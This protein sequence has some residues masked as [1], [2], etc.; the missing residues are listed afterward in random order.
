MRRGHLIEDQIIGMLREHEAGVKIADLCRRHGIS[1][2]IYYNWMARYGALTVSD[3]A[4]L[5][6]LKDEN[7]R[8][9]KRWRSRCWTCRR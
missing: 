3:T 1:N 9:K 7:R 5:R 8:L 2:A 6:A 4:R